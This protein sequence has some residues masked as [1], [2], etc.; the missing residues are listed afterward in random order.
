MR[1][2]YVYELKASFASFQVQLLERGLPCRVKAL[3]IFQELTGQTLP[4]VM[5]ISLLMKTIQP[6]QSN[7]K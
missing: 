2:I 4:V 1:Q 5:R 7:P 3:S 6:G